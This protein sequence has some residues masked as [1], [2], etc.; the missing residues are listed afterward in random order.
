M[1]Y[2]DCLIAGVGWRLHDL[3]RKGCALLPSDA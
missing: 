1:K 3:R 2:L